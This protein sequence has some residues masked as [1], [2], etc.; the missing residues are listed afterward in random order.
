MSPAAS[1]F[2]VIHERVFRCA[3]YSSPGRRSALYRLWNRVDSLRA[4]P[5]RSLHRT[6]PLLAARLQSF[7]AA[8]WRGPGNSAAFRRVSGITLRRNETGLDPRDVDRHFLCAAARLCS[9]SPAHEAYS[10]R[11]ALWRCSERAASSIDPCCDKRSASSHRNSRSRVARHRN[12]LFD[13]REDAP[14]PESC[15]SG[16][17]SRRWHSRFDSS[18]EPDF[19]RCREGLIVCLA[20]RSSTNSKNKKARFHFQAPGFLFM[21]A[22][23][24][25]LELLQARSKSNTS[26]SFTPVSSS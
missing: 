13:G 14:S 6:T 2:E 25:P 24:G 19:S 11:A 15:P 22:A 20:R 8:F 7:T 23:N 4:V 26:A 1:L 12:S 21:I 18:V 9:D 3:L 16:N 17:C 10:H 5:K